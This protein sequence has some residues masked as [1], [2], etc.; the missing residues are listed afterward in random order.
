MIIVAEALS[1]SAIVDFVAS[2]VVLCLQVGCLASSWRYEG[3][4]DMFAGNEPAK[5][6]DG[7]RQYVEMQQAPF[8]HGKEMM[9]NEGSARR[10]GCAA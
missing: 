6:P 10:N 2:V 7:R 8:A 4:V 3:P 1:L 9:L 5:T